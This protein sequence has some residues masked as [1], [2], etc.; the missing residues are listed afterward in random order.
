MQ[1]GY[2]PRMKP[3]LF[4]TVAHE[5]KEAIWEETCEESKNEMVPHNV[6]EE[7]GAS[8]CEPMGQKP[9]KPEER[10]TKSRRQILESF[11]EPKRL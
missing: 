3:L 7:G 2:G 1:S 5:P 9:E 10:A 6:G 4:Q 8:D 11:P